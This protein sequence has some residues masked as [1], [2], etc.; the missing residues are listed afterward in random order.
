MT[1][2]F[3]RQRKHKITHVQVIQNRLWRHNLPRKLAS[4]L[5]CIRGSRRE[6]KRKRRMSL[7]FKR[8]N[9]LK[10]RISFS[11]FSSPLF[12]THEFGKVY[13]NFFQEIVTSSSVLDH[14]DRGNES[15]YK[16]KICF[17]VVM[18]Y[19]DF[20]YATEIRIDHQNRRN[21]IT[22]SFSLK[23]MK[24]WNCQYLGNKMKYET[25]ICYVEVANNADFHYGIEIR[26]N[27]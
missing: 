9:F 2:S 25:E 26:T 14:Q 24:I 21:L 23:T 27:C 18:F 6:S 15:K 4:K 13:G 7:L 16:T 3:W 20:Y 22:S 8:V 11:F 10:N 19:A 12:W 1:S 17:L 5:L